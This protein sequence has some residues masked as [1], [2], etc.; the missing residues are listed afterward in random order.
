M[1]NHAILQTAQTILAQWTQRTEE[2]EPTRLDMYMRTEDIAE[3]VAALVSPG[4]WHLSAITGLDI[5]QTQHEDGSI[6][7]LYHFCQRAVV[8]T[9][10]IR[11]SY[12]SPIIPT[13][14]RVI[15]SATLYEREMIEMFGVIIEGTPSRDKLLLPDD[16]PDYVYPMRKS[17]QGLD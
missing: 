13:I 14:C 4:G 10:R 12:G 16:W 6:E 8:V 11:V 1:D 9:L 5:P 7:L 3:A 15:P 17:F 2:P